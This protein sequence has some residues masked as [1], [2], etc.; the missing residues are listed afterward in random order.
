M[1]DRRTATIVLLLIL[2]AAAF[3]RFWN[4]GDLPPG[5][6]H[7]E[8]YN[9]LDALS[10]L[11]GKSFPQFYEGWELYTQDA[12]AQRPP[13]ESRFPIFFEGNYGREP[14]HVYLMALS[15][16]LLDA[17][18]VAIR[19]V[20]AAAGVL[21]VLTTFFAARAL[22]PDRGYLIP[23]TA[24]AVIAIIYPAVHFS[25]FGIRAML[26]VPFE[27]LTVA[28]F[29]KGIN[30]GYENK[31]GN[32]VWPWFAVAGLFLGLSIYT[33]AS[34]RIFPLLWV[35]FTPLWFLVDK[36]AYQRFRGKM[37]VMALAATLTA[38]PLLLFFARYP[39]YFLFRISYVANKGSGTVE[40]QPWLTWTYNVGR[41]LRGFF[42]RGETHLRHNLPGRPYFDII[43]LAF[44]LIGLGRTFL[45]IKQIRFLFLVLWFSIMMLPSI[46]SG[47]AP[48]FGRLIGAAAPAAI[49]IALG[50]EWFYIKLVSWLNQHYSESTA[51]FSA[52]GIIILL[53][54]AS[55]VW[56][57][58]DYFVRYNRHPALAS[59][60]YQDDWEL[61][62]FAA[63][64]GEKSDIYLSPGQEELATILFA[65]PDVDQLRNFNAST[66]LVPAGRE[67]RDLIFL[68]KEGEEHIP[69]RI[70]EIF[71]VGIVAE[72]VISSNIL[73]VPAGSSRNFGL[74]NQE[75]YF[76]E[77]IKLEGWA[78]EV[79]GQELLVTLA[80]ESQK[81][82]D[83]NYTVF[84]HVMDNNGNMI[85]QVDREPRGYPTSDWRLSEVVID[86]FLLQIPNDELS[87][88]DYII[89]TGF[90]YLPTLEG[91][92]EPVVLEEADR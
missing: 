91:L 46:L 4:L 66:S 71:D 35:L 39:Y 41:V 15:I 45:R 81:L 64:F 2:I 61:G 74:T 78:S 52:A 3:F 31:P 18:P 58:V 29:M 20:P 54:F 92:G 19:A 12:H 79:E 14:F 77:R 30:D 82:L 44:F 38:L 34:A 73:H 51:S 88:Q 36:A 25:R 87:D 67:N 22:F 50:V 24:A 83:E 62:L 75:A 1:E 9:G 11:Q 90:Y 57:G 42:Y 69:G 6:Y 40:G 60:F 10:L 63:S 43:Q 5:L 27:T 65:L 23:L 68:F 89:K 86:Q 17:T 26:F 76:D 49:I 16:A 55:A 33:F 80:W 85:S 53:W 56:T 84:V 72:P 48:H 7:D 28:C 47:D 21:A 37:S 70:L 8:A 59:D 13:Q 32:K